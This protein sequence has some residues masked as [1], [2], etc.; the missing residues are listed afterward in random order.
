M[1]DCLNELW[2]GCGSHRDGSHVGWQEQRNYFSPLENEIYF[3]EK[4]FIAAA[5]PGSITSMFCTINLGNGQ[6]HIHAFPGEV[7]SELAQNL[8][9][10]VKPFVCPYGGLQSSFSMS[11]SV[12]IKGGRKPSN[13]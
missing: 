2:D 3:H 5:K 9:L 8:W 10:A 7:P 11:I 6:S 13:M 1:T 4:R 12:L